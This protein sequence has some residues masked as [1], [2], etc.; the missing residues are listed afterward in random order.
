MHFIKKKNYKAIQY[1]MSFIVQGTLII[2]L[3]CSGDKIVEEEFSRRIYSESCVASWEDSIYIRTVLSLST[4]GKYLVIPDNDNHRL[5]VTNLSLDLLRVVGKEGR[6]PGEF[7]SV[8]QTYTKR[9]KIYTFDYEN[10]RISIHRLN[11]DYETEIRVT[12]NN[13]AAPRFVVDSLNNYF[14][15]TP[16][17]GS[18][19][20][21]I[22]KDGTTIH[23]FGQQ[24]GDTRNVCHIIGGNNGEIFLIYPNFPII[25]KYDNVGNLKEQED[26][27][28]IDLVKKSY[29]H[30]ISY[31]S[32]MNYDWNRSSIS[33]IGDV[34][35][36]NEKLYLLIAEHP[37]KEGND[38]IMYANKVLVYTTTPNM[39]FFEV[40]E[41]AEPNSSDNFI[42]L[43]VS[44]ENNF[45]AAFELNSG[46]ICK[47][48]LH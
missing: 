23:T 35:Y 34:Y 44:E 19:V 37:E 5:L 33:T 31:F 21:Y 11:G 41:L 16:F 28:K 39:K 45:L 8:F 32:K 18:S 27:M 14:F 26:L 6:G 3:G 40:I 12:T 30:I 4:D 22:K 29:D 9:D 48:I 20:S 24:F 13:F 15:S 47:F 2:V 42:T 10:S 46:S 43:C 17:E 25:E 1:I 38:E 36:D 7:I